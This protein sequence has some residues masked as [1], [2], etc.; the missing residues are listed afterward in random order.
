MNHMLMVQLPILC[1]VLM[2]VCLPVDRPPVF[3]QTRMY[4][5]AFLVPLLFPTPS[6]IGTVYQS[7]FLFNS[8]LSAALTLGR[9]R[10]FFLFAFFILKTALTAVPG[11]ALADMLSGISIAENKDA[12]GKHLQ[13]FAAP[14]VT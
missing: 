1:L 4:S 5:R 3:K 6:S 2:C 13:P 14:L 9:V 11:A 12:G 10:A 8:D 7:L